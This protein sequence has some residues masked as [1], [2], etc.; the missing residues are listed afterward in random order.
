MKVLTAAPSVNKVHSYNLRCFPNLTTCFADMKV[1]VKIPRDTRAMD[2]YLDTL[3]LHRGRREM[4]V[5]QPTLV[6][7][8][9]CS[10]ALHFAPIHWCELVVMG[11][12]SLSNTGHCW[13]RRPT[14]S[15]CNKK[16]AF[17]PRFP[18]PWQRIPLRSKPVQIS[19]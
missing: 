7:F 16:E 12:Y 2:V 1:Q 9:Y 13:E 17:G 8:V 3:Y 4:S 11:T 10:L 6:L 15:N 5:T 14:Y 19:A 18:C